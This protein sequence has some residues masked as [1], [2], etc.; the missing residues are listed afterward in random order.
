MIGIPFFLK[1]WLLFHRRKAKFSEKQYR[2]LLTVLSESKF[3]ILP[4]NNFRKWHDKGKVIIGLRHDV[5]TD[6]FKALRMAQI[7]Q[8]Y[9]IYST[10]FFLSTAW[11]AGK[12]KKDGLKRND[13]DWLYLAIWAIGHEIAVHNDL[14]T[15]I[16]KYKLDPFEFNRQELNYFHSLGIP[17][18]ETSSHGSEIAKKLHISNFDI[19]SD[20]AKTK[21]T[22]P[23]KGTCYLIGHNS[24]KEYGYEC[25]SYHLDHNIYIS[26]AGGCF[27]IDGKPVSFDEVIC[28]LKTV[29]RGNRIQLLIHPEHYKI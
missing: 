17:I 7:E 21:L 15:V 6:P 14:L 8:E 12:I 28:K 29:E 24:L 26:D 9:K 25:E 18:Y 13:L 27:K 2:E 11:Y 16:S 1:L 19:F 23:Y 4:L 3:L 5:D 10:F 20:F 22:M